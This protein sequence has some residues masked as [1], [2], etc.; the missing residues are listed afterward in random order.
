[1]DLIENMCNRA[2]WLER[3]KIIEIGNAQRVVDKYLGRTS[4]DVQDEHEDSQI[5]P[6]EQRWGSQRLIITRV[7]ILG[8]KFQPKSIFNT[9]DKLVLEM[10]YAVRRPVSSP[11]FGIAIH[12]RDG[13]HVTGPNTHTAGFELGE[14]IG[15]GKIIYT[16]PH[17]Q[18]LNGDYVFSVSA[19]N[20]SDTELYDYHDIAYPFQV[21]N[22]PDIGENYG[23]VTLQG[24]WQHTP[25]S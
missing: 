23:V 6:P 10:E 11:V 18:L 13:I 19:T 3:G 21:I 20:E 2:A 14:I 25:S 9:G 16:I 15:T 8:E 5:A 1:M 7:R 12:R 24:E 22:D 4:E 17:L